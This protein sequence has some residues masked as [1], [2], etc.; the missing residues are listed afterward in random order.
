MQEKLE[1][2]GYDIGPCGADGDFGDDT[3][4]AVVKFQRDHKLEPIDGEIGNDT[5]TAIEAALWVL[6]TAAENPEEP[7]APAAEPEQ[8]I[9]QT[10]FWPP[11]TLRTGMKG[12]DVEVLSALLKA[13]GWNVH[14]VDENFGS[15]LEGKVREF[16]TAYGLEATGIVDPATWDRLLKRT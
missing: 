13:R 16:Q 1:K 2:L 11:R 14:Y 4:D 6:E 9:P 5:Y 7:E 10:E 15:F 12:R 8:Q 3:Y